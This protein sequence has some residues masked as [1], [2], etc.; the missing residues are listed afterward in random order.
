MKT[1]TIVLF[2]LLIILFNPTTGGAQLL[3]PEALEKSKE[4]SQ[5][6]IVHSYANLDFVLK[7]DINLAYIDQ[8]DLFKAI[9]RCSKLQQLRIYS[10]VYRNSDAVLEAFVNNCPDLQVLNTHI[11]LRHFP[12]GITKLK[13]LSSLRSEDSLVQPEEDLLKIAQIKSLKSLSL[14][15]IG[16]KRLPGEFAQLSNLEELSLGTGLGVG[17]EISTWQK[18]ELDLPVIYKLTKLKTLSLGFNTI[19]SIPVGIESLR[20]L[21]VLRLVYTKLESLPE[22]FGQLTSLKELDLG[23]NKLKILPASFGNLVN[24]QVLDISNN[25]LAF[26][27]ASFGKLRNLRDLTLTGCPDLNWDLESG[28]LKSLDSLRSLTIRDSKMN[29][30]PGDLF[31]ISHLE[32]ME[33][34]G[35]PIKSIPEVVGHVKKGLYVYLVNTPLVKDTVE[36]QRI[37]KANPETYFMYEYQCF[38]AGTLITMAD[39]SHRAIEEIQEGDQVMGYS[40]AEKEL[41]KV[42]V[43]NTRKFDQHP[44]LLLEIGFNE[45]GAVASLR[46]GASLKFFSMLLSPYHPVYTNELGWIKASELKP[47]YTV[48]SCSTGNPELREIKVRSV[49]KCAVPSP[50]VYNLKTGSSNYFANGILVHNK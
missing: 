39:G 50:V 38:P 37:Q 42:Y 11:K 48:L 26:L 33:L 40:V 45:A 41:K 16:F 20:S 35:N 27:P 10:S 25:P 49:E 18:S 22:R 1:N 44:H 12:K 31:L 15:A 47:E 32:E 19:H 36:Q 24:L 46:K 13:Y 43:K 29:H 23:G 8:Q 2:I 3:S 6:D 9:H 30:V 14:F 5:A 21:Q 4:Y 34:S 28:K 7:L 17:Q